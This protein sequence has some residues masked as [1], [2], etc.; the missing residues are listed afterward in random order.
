MKFMVTVAAAL[1]VLAL[2]SAVEESKN[3]PAFVH[4]LKKLQ[5]GPP[6]SM[7]ASR[8]VTTEWITQK[9]DHF[10]ATNEKTWQMVRKS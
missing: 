8:A 2:V 5:R 7:V 4:T 3:E 1:A 10:D 9:L 6:T